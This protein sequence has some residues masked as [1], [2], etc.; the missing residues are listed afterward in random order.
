MTTQPVYKSEA[1]VM[2]AENEEIHNII[3]L[4]SAHNQG[5]IA[6]EIEILKSRGLKSKLVIDLW[7]SPLR[8][9]LYILGNRNIS[10]NNLNFFE[11][12]NV[13]AKRFQHSII[14]RIQYY[15]KNTFKRTYNSSELR[16]KYNNQKDTNFQNKDLWNLRIVNNLPI[17]LNREKL[18]NIVNN[19][20]IEITPI[21]ETS[22]INITLESH[23]RREAEYIL[24]KF[25]EIYKNSDIS[26]NARE[27]NNM[28]SF[29]EKK[30]QD[31][32]QELEKAR[33]RLKNYQSR[34]AVF[35]IDENNRSILE[36]AT[37]MEAQYYQIK[38][39]LES[40]KMELKNLKA[41]LSSEEK[42]L[43]NEILNTL[44]SELIALREELAKNQAMLVK[45]RHQYGNSH[46]QI[47]NIEGNIKRIKDEITAKTKQYTKNGIRI[48]D[49]I[50][51]SQNLVSRILE[52]ESEVSALELR[53]REYKK[54]LDKYDQKIREL[55]EK[56]LLYA[57]YRRELDVLEENYLFLRQ[58]YEEAKISRAFESG[59][60]KI[61][62]H[63]SFARKLKPNPKKDIIMSLL[64]GIGLSFLFIVLKDS[65]GKKIQSVE[66]LEW[67]DLPLIGK[68]PYLKMNEKNTRNGIDKSIV[69]YHQPNSDSAELFRKL[70]TNIQFSSLESPIKAIIVT[71]HN[72][73]EGKTTI[74]GNL[75]I[76]YATLGK[77]VLLVDT[78]LRKSNIH[79]I[80]KIDKAPGLTQFLNGKSDIK[81][82]IKPS[83]Y[84]N[85]YV[86]PAGS[87]PPNPAEL[88]DSEK[89]NQLIKE[90]K[91]YWDIIIFDAP[92]LQPVTDSLILC[93]DMDYIII[94]SF[95]NRTRIDALID[96]IDE[97]NKINNTIG[98]V[99][100]T[101]IKRGAMKYNY[102]KYY[103]YEPA[104][105]AKKRTKK[106][107]KH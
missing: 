13:K 100:L 92:P 83:S 39:E 48:S 78:D 99:V 89:M 24:G 107:Q 22:I 94:S 51:Y 69:T 1:N 14:K 15:L 37:E 80:F 71:S 33:V 11:R 54:I 98:G 7:S 45:T 18:E 101:G 32:E 28:T 5:A 19:L 75:A 67:Y 41:H 72:P 47:K 81:D 93:K 70:R 8:D 60:V 31:Q 27:I 16:N 3:D 49:P 58:R 21:P 46:D 82:I 9:S 2:I 40:K 63:A 42:K 59:N 53:D 57:K 104:N 76:I 68:I 29:L 95:Y 52:T 55:P 20:N 85:L 64:V 25:I 6:N 102:K 87:L 61:I 86:I 91:S 66:D 96:S 105:N 79:N 4:R 10:M 44:N 106:P 50:R 97:I 43:V 84:E 35:G 73:Q 74:A 38:I 34:A 36:Q 56:Q 23:G 12:I 62:D 65:F 90:L 26:R 103:K 88:I 30:I 17:G 77:N